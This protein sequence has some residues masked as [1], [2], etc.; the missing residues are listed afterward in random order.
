MSLAKTVSSLPDILLMGPG[1]SSIHDDVYR[2][3]S[4]HTIG[5]MDPRFIELMNESKAMLQWLLNTDNRLTLPIS[6]TGSSGMDTCFLNLVEPGDPILLLINGVFGVRMKELATK[7]G[8]KVDTVECTWGTPIDVQLVKEKLE[9]N[10][11]KLVAIVHAET[12]TGVRNPVEEIGSLVK[13][14]GALYMVDT[15]TSLGGIPVM[16][17]KWGIDALFSGTQKCLSCP[18]GLSPL[19][20]SERALET[21][22]NR[23]SPVQSWY[24]DLS[25][26]IKYW[27]GNSRVY[28]HT[29]PINMVYALYQALALIKEE[30]TESVFKRHMDAHLMLVKE[31]EAI[32]LTMLVDKAYR[33]PMLNAVNIPAGADDAA[34]RSTLLREHNIEIGGGLGPLAGK[35]WRI[36]VMGHTARPENIQRLIKALKAVLKK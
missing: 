32:G 24:L 2:A 5:H 9:K 26:I 33:L 12:S 15:V 34:V 21:L 11:Y 14:N 17:D 6:G 1:P 35:I 8:A 31:L 22:A 23:K 7:L 36:G 10:K 29:A 30:G 20:F 18:P 27:D 28:H 25:M 13:E 4:H 3:M 19:S 16:M